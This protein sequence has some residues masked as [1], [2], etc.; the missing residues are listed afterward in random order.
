[1]KDN[2]SLGDLFVRHLVMA[3]PWSIILL[4]VMFI[5]AVGIKQQVKESIQYAIRM[6]IQET[7]NFAYSYNVVVPVKKNVK[8]GIEFVAKTAKNEIKSL[9][10]D[11]EIKQDIKEALEYS[12]EK[13]RK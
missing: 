7:A 12:G 10:K 1:M 13:F 5:S 6:S 3:I 9:L 2:S 11:P 4:L 8:E